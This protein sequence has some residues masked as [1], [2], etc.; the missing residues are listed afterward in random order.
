MHKS[1]KIQCY[2][3]ALKK[4]IKE[5]NFRGSKKARKQLKFP[6][7]TRTTSPQIF[8]KKK[9]KMICKTVEWICVCLYLRRLALAFASA[10]CPSLHSSANSNLDTFACAIDVRVSLTHNIW[11]AP[12]GPRRA[13]DR[14][15][16][17]SDLKEFW[18][19]AHKV[20]INQRNEMKRNGKKNIRKFCFC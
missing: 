18:G 13:T 4:C 12:H 10:S 17:F 7:I 8:V 5:I 15:I 9:R 11:L 1:N 16:W 14:V 20:E 6:K 2:S 3:M 19:R